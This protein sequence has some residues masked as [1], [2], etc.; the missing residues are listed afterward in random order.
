MTRSILRTKPVGEVIAEAPDYGL[1]RALSFAD[2]S[3]IGFAAV[4]SAGVFIVLGESAARFGGPATVVSIVMAAVVTTGA[5][6]C[7]AELASS[8]PVSGS[9][10]TYTYAR[11]GELPAYAIG[12]MLLLQYVAFAATFAIGWSAYLVSFL[13]RLGID[14]PYRFAASPLG[15]PLARE[16]GQSGAGNLPAA[17]I[18][19]VFTWLLVAGVRE[20][21]RGNA[22][23]TVLKALIAVGLIAPVLVYFTSSN[24]APFV[25]ANTGRWGEFG[26][27]G[28]W[29]SAGFLMFIFAGADAVATTAQESRNPRRDLT[30]GIVA[31]V[32]V[33]TILYVALCVGM[34]GTVPYGDLS[35]ANVVSVL[36]NAIGANQAFSMALEFAILLVITSSVLT[37]LLSGPRVLY[38]LSRDG[39]LPPVL[40]RIHPVYRTPYVATIAG[41]VAVAAV[42]ALLP[43]V[44]VV[45]FANMAYLVS[46]A[47]ICGGL[48]FY[49]RMVPAPV[50]VYRAPFGAALPIVSLA[51]CLALL[52]ALMLSDVASGLQLLIAIALG[53]VIYAGYGYRNSTLRTDATRGSGATT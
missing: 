30:I 43:L 8:V 7:Y 51:G 53:G 14:I 11:L 2:L 9:A 52:G 34:V 29:A 50:A 33:T 19:V 12:W 24:L 38:A 44:A 25:P 40:A 13:A 3:L 35:A 28:V 5:V 31:S 32:V 1:K 46:L 47:I 17:L 36:L 39:L 23:L 20:S 15:E 37:L 48:L 42:A 27:S 6:L 4:F 22:V 16:G 45:R 26:W 18:V 21:A 49:R 10:Y 41:G